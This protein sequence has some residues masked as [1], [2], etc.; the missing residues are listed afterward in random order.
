MT[1]PAIARRLLAMLRPLAPLMLVSSGCRVVNQGLG[2]AIP[3][4]AAALV[5]GIGAGG[6]VAALVVLL[7]GMAVVKGVFRYVE[8]FTGHA[9]AF[10]LL[11]TLRVDTYRQIEPLAPAGLETERTGDLVARVVGDVDR[12]EPFYAHTIAPLAS[13]VLVPLFAAGGLALWV[14]PVL[15]L[16]FLPFPLAIALV[17]PWIRSRRV[18]ELSAEGRRLGGEAG[19]VLTDAVQGAREIA[20]MRA[21]PII[22][23]RIDR[24]SSAASH[25]RS[26]LARIASTRSVVADLLSGAAVVA[27]AGV[28][29]ARLEGGLVDLAGLAAAVAVAWVGTTPARALE[30]I[31]P[32]LEQALAAAGRLFELADRLPPV[33]PA[34]FPGPVPADGSVSLDGVTVQ[35]GERLALEDVTLDI[36]HGA[37]LAVVGP[38]GSGKT[39]LVELLLRFRDP[40]SGTI[41][42]GGHDV[43]EID[44]GVLRDGVGLV[45]QRPEL[46]FG[47]IGDNLRLAR[48]D[49]SDDE[50]REALER[51]AL[52]EW[53]STL[54][55]GLD[56]PVG[57]LGETISGGQRQRLAVARA[58]L[59]DPRVVVLDEATSEL[60]PA[61]EA[62]VL[63]TV[64]G[65]RGRRTVIVVAHRLETVTGADEIVVLDAGRV[66]ERGRHDD[67][68]S[69]GGVYAGLWR[70]HEDV[71]GVA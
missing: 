44:D 70:R 23:E 1:R 57:E 61:T 69:A 10:S 21:E 11:S 58:L 55:R 2:V 13:A 67:L 43:R 33:I 60:D 18:A 59:R 65:E 63:D 40:D 20:V 6:S 53:V 36:P 45:P 62:Q 49:A 38:S 42:V 29:L 17:I 14:D 35:L 19:A 54:D 4:V 27:V 22:A 64:A 66:V 41:T 28:G 56:T 37:Y 8:Q 71:V 52:R 47:T 39:T 7:A 5:I 32:D 9:V 68:I 46:F 25:V 26:R 30:D 24:A 3:A 12:V 48:P 34:P 51:A 50:L 16:V 31:V 15:A